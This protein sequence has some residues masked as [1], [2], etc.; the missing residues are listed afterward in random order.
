[1]TYAELSYFDGYHFRHIAEWEELRRLKNIRS[2][3]KKL[4][5]F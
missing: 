3:S 2:Q 1:M 5:R 4:N